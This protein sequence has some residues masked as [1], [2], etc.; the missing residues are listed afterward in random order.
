MNPSQFGNYSRPR[1]LAL[2]VLFIA[3]SSLLFKNQYPLFG[4]NRIFLG[5]SLLTKNLKK[6]H[7]DDPPKPDSLKS[8]PAIEVHAQVTTAALD[9]ILTTSSIFHDTRIQFCGCW[10]ARFPNT[11]PPSAQSKVIKNFVKNSCL[12]KSDDYE[13]VRKLWARVG[14]RKNVE[15]LFHGS[16]NR[17]WYEMSNSTL[18]LY[19]ESRV[20][21]VRC[22]EL[23]ELV[24]HLSLYSILHVYWVFRLEAWGLCLGFTCFPRAYFPALSCCICPWVVRL[25]LS[26]QVFS[27]EILPSVV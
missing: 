23:V 20:L 19:T 16:T 24:W 15:V 8:S 13:E 3:N 27:P 11:N 4:N 10:K 6:S 17:N 2:F 26:L 22:S 5:N 14:E 18:R 7:A 1:T 21:P 9:L 25:V 12:C